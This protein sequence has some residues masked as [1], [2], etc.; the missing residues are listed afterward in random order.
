MDSIF[1]SRSS[2]YNLQ[3]SKMHTLATL[4]DEA[5]TSILGFE[6]T[7]VISLFL[8]GSADFAIR[9]KRCCFAFATPPGLPL[10][11]KWPRL[12]SEL[13]NLS[14]VQFSATL[15]NQPMSVFSKE[16]R[17][18][19][20][21]LKKLKICVPKSTRILALADPSHPD[22]DF[23]WHH[24]NLDASNGRF[25]IGEL[26]NVAE[27]YPALEEFVLGDALFKGYQRLPWTSL[28]IY[29][30]TLRMLGIEGITV[31]ESDFSL[32]PRGLTSLSVACILVTAKESSTLP[33]GLANLQG[34]RFKSL[35][36]VR[37]V[38]TSLT[39]CFD[40]DDIGGNSS[41]VSALI[42][43]P[44]PNITQVRSEYLNFVLNSAFPAGI[45]HLTNFNI[46]N[47]IPNF[48]QTVAWH[49]K[50]QPHYAQYPPNLRSIEFKPISSVYSEP[51]PHDD[52]I[53]LP[54]NA[55]RLLNLHIADEG[56]QVTVFKKASAFPPNLVE[57]SIYSRTKCFEDAGFGSFEEEEIPEPVELEGDLEAS[58]LP[59]TLK[60][61]SIL[62]VIDQASIAS[63]ELKAIP[64]TLTSL[65]LLGIDASLI[66]L[67]PPALTHL[68]IASLEGRITEDIF[69]TLPAHMTSLDVRIALGAFL[70]PTAFNHLPES[71]Y[72]LTLSK[73]D[74]SILKDIPTRIK[75]LV[76][77]ISGHHEKTFDPSSIPDR[78]TRWLSHQPKP[79]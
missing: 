13:P 14:S 27:C 11:Y 31:S 55:T 1:S 36:A 45:T 49:L 54:K 65:E 57:L 47:M 6:P 50:R 67:L 2:I 39:G 62:P 77:Q 66:P 46:S 28:S 40:L 79:H 3:T 8:C 52:L 23:L 7:C 17:T 60:S 68:R 56:G 29:P 61:L 64:P 75:R 9:L 30:P 44:P 12:L 33:P 25:H 42:S 38:P 74:V 63:E 78:W 15:L 32:L 73:I 70:D 53:G 20:R 16:V 48:V 37:A 10:A 69:K 72:S 5:L 24:G 76:A 18:L 34:A 51:I 22:R 41:L 59:S 43:S 58:P 19:P 35:E 26:W 4:S 21:T 71:L